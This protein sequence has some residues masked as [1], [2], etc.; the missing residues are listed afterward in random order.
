MSVGKFGKIA[1]RESSEEDAVTPP[2]QVHL[3][4]D[5]LINIMQDLCKTDKQEQLKDSFL[6][7]HSGLDSPPHE[8][9]VPDSPAIPRNE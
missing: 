4:R 5:R 6:E 9:Q 2:G 7:E 3:I 1:R 8:R